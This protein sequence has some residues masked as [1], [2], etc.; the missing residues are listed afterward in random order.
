MAG[1]IKG[2][3]WA[4]GSG[5]PEERPRSEGI[6]TQCGEVLYGGGAALP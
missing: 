2:R 3:C 4:R 5:G 1:S 6:S